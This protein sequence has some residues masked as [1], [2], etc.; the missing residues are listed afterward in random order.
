MKY[1]RHK[2]NFKKNKEQERKQ[3]N[4]VTPMKEVVTPYN[5]ATDARAVARLEDGTIVFV[6]D[7]LP[8]E[9]AL[10]KINSGKSSYKRASVLSRENDCP[11]RALPP[12]PYYEQCG[13]CQMQHLRLEKQ[14]EYKIQWFF[15]TLKRLGKWDSN[16]VSLAEK[17][18]EVSYLKT[19][20]YRRRIK[21]HFDGK[22]LGFHEKESHQIISIESCYIARPMLNE[23]LQFLKKELPLVVKQIQSQ[24]PSVNLAFDIE[25]TESDD[26]KVLIHLIHVENKEVLSFLQKYFQIQPDQLIHL[27]HPQFGR[28]RL[29]KESFVQPHFDALAHYV[30][31]MSQCVELFLEKL[32]KHHNSFI[33]WD[34]F[35]G[36]GVFSAIPYL[37]AE[38]NGRSCQTLAVEGVKEAIESLQLN[39]KE[40]P[41]EGIVQDVHE[42]I[43]Q[44]F[45]KRLNQQSNNAPHIVIL[46]PPRA[47]VGIPNMQRLVELCAH[48]CCILYLACDPA[49]FARDTRILLEGGFHNRKN[50]LFDSFGQTHFYEV[51]GFFVKGVSL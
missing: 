28:F 15:E 20:H 46:D 38:K 11:A 32:P 2:Q 4:A 6:D 41:I 34:L 16:H 51:L 12:C 42:F 24:F 17:K 10:V 25:L 48:E 31:A 50:V 30:R 13:G 47:G 44:Q 35:A 8:G 22:N 27:K 19:D 3:Q 9:K 23:K 33:A 21:L 5:L 40:R 36:S 43:D 29:R 1:H 39:H 45:E 49:S 26:E 7:L 14:S 18:L 37:A